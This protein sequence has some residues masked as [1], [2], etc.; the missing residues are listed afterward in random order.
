VL[1][2]KVLPVRL[3]VR[4]RRVLWNVLL[5]SITPLAP[6]WKV[7]REHMLLVLEPEDRSRSHMLRDLRL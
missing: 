4:L 3:H 2:F 7:S 1:M 6:Y 5:V